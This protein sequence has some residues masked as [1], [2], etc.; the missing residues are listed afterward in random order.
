MLRTAHAHGLFSYVFSKKHGFIRSMS[1]PSK[2]VMFSHDIRL[3]EK[4]NS[5][6]ILKILAYIIIDTLQITQMP[7][8]WIFLNLPMQLKPGHVATCCLFYYFLFETCIFCFKTVRFVHFW[9]K[10]ALKQPRYRPCKKHYT[11]KCGELNWILW[12]NDNND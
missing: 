12:L 7:N 8:L 2:I 6:M 5:F 3:G 4:S 1:P 9:P 10:H 11:N